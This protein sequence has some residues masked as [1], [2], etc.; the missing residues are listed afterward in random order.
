MAR[1]CRGARE[2]GFVVLVSTAAEAEAQLS[3][4]ALRDL[5]DPAFDEVAGELP[6]PQRRA[7]AVTL[8]RRGAADRPLDAGVIGAAVLSALRVLGARSRPLLA[9]DD[10]Q[11]L[12]PASAAVLA[13]VLRRLDRELVAGLLTR[14]SE[15]AD[16]LALDR[17]EPGVWPLIQLG[18]LAVGA[19]GRVV[20]ERLGVT[21]ARP[22]LHRIADTSGGESVLRARA[23]VCARQRRSAPG[24]GRAASG[25]AGAG[26]LATARLVLLP[27]K[28]L[29]VLPDAVAMSRPHPAIVRAAA[30]V[31]PL[32]LLA[33]AIAA[34]IVEVRAD[35]L[36][37]AHP[38]FAASVYGLVDPSTRRE[39]HGRLATVVDDVEERAR[40]L[41]L[42]AEGPDRGV[43]AALEAAAGLAARRGAQE[44]ATELAE[45]ACRA[46]PPDEPRPC[47]GGS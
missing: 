20:R 18:G 9:V 40:H 13:Y 8:L 36:R 14:R 2:R 30:C 19:L 38:L 12:D 45:L 37:F 22:T 16:L 23:G 7:L 35:A 34:H 1:V 46:T 11:W 42:A 26:Q 39:V 43:A 17:L 32:P 25:A 10:V 5:L 28:T 3:F 27:E 6:D 47:G 21:Y 31:D 24:S 44:A 15:H 4:T 33:P 29:E 41:A